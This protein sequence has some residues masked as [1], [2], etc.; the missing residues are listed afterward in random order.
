MFDSDSAALLGM[1]AGQPQMNALR[2]NDIQHLMILIFDWRRAYAEGPIMV[3]RRN[4][5]WKVIISS[6]KQ[7]EGIKSLQEFFGGRRISRYTGT[8]DEAMANEYLSYVM[9]ELQR[10]MDP[11]VKPTRIG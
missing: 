10:M 9:E 1:I 7:K 2:M 4:R 8:I 6:T 11:R 3:G 5:L